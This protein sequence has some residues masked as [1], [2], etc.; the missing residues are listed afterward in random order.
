MAGF[1]V[2]WRG[3]VVL[4]LA[5]ALT[6]V[7]GALAQDSGPILASDTASSSDPLPFWGSIDCASASRHQQ[8]TVGG[9]THVKADGTSQGDSS[10]RRLTVIDGDDFSGERC[11]L[12]ENNH[13]LDGDPSPGPTVFYEEGDRRITYMSFRLPTGFP[14]SNDWWQVVMQMKQTGPANNSGGTPVLS[15]NAYNGRWRL[16]KSNSVESGSDTIEIWSVAASTG[17]W[18]RFAFDV[19]YSQDSSQGWVKVYVDLNNDGDFADTDET[20]GTIATYTLKRETAG[21]SGDGLAQGDSIPSHLRTGIYHNPSYTCA[22]PTGC[23]VDVDNV[24]VVD[25]DTTAP[26]ATITA[27]PSGTTM[28]TSAS[29]EFTSSETGSTFTCSLDGGA[30]GSCSSPKSYSSLAVGTHTFRVK[31]RDAA[32]NEDSTPAERT[33]E[34]DTSTYAAAVRDDSPQSYW[35]FNAS[36]G[37][38]AAPQVGSISGAHGSGA[39]AGAASLG[40]QLGASVDYSGA[41]GAETSFGDNLDFSGTQAFSVEAW[42][43]P[44]T[45]DATYRRV[46]SKQSS[47]GGTQGYTLYSVTGVDGVGFQRFRDGVADTAKCSQLGSGTTY[48]LVGTYDGS[49]LRLYRNGVQCASIASTRSLTDN[50]GPFLVGNTSILTGRNFD[51]RIDEPAVYS[52]ALSS[53]EV[54]EHYLAGP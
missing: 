19:K 20:S 24:Q 34:V 8:V 10:L 52:R 11:E 15:L 33:W 45:V 31:A 7:D 21:S 14:M 30:Y 49:T 39:S 43:R 2:T 47:T 32:G 37:S 46:F 9:D 5:I 51:G 48:H 35:R 13:G 36:S 41:S 50:T 17:V 53:T 22:S 42:I 4:A 1:D 25:P 6:G 27:G 44:D 40:T 38:T 12:G 29:F 28:S 3:V 23:Y 54:S 26:E 18:T 16:R